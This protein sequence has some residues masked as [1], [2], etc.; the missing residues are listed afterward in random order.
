MILQRL[1]KSRSY[2]TTLKAALTWYGLLISQSTS[3]KCHQEIV[4]SSQVDSG[5]PQV[6]PILP[7]TT[8]FIATPQRARPHCSD[9][10][11]PPKKKQKDSTAVEDGDSPDLS[12]GDEATDSGIQAITLV[13]HCTH[14]PRLLSADEKCHCFK[15]KYE[16]LT[17][18]DILVI[19][20]NRWR[21]SVYNHYKPPQ[22]MPGPNGTSVYCFVCK[23]YPNKHIDRADSEDSTGNLRWHADYCDPDKTPEAELLSTYTHGVTYT[24][25]RMQLLLTLWCAWHHCPYAIIEDLEIQEIFWMLYLRV[26]IPSHTTVSRN[27]RVIHGNM[28]EALVEL[29]ARPLDFTKLRFGRLFGR[30]DQAL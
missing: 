8:A 25:A 11:S 26:Y 7:T 29:L 18:A 1:E 15:E 20:S 6:S 9:V 3:S 27:V 17:Q 10:A 22:I 5:A 19:V 2:K 16:D 12:G 13:A 21:S 30:Q 24:A 14:R 23:Q 28:Q 4:S